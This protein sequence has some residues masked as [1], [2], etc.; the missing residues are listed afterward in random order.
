MPIRQNYKSFKGLEYMKM[1]LGVSDI[2]FFG[3][4]DIQT[5]IFRFGLW[6]SCKNYEMTRPTRFGAKAHPLRDPNLI[7]KNTFAECFVS[8]Y[9]YIDRVWLNHQT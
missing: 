8:I 4:S 9:P 2:V 5:F 1:R 7:R 6:A 3:L